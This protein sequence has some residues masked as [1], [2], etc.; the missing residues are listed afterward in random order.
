MLKTL[1]TDA[2]TGLQA[3]VVDREEENALVVATR[4]LKTFTNKVIFFSND[5]YGIDMNVKPIS[6]GVPEKVHNG[7]DNVL[8][9]ASDIVGG[10]KTAFD[11]ADQNH[12]GGG[13]KSV[14]IDNSP[15]ND[16]F[17][18]D[19]GSDLDCSGYA[20]LTMWIYVDKDW[21]AGD[22]IK[23]YG[24][25]TGTGL[26]VGTAV[27]L[28]NYFFWS[29]F[30][31]WRKLTIPLTDMGALASYT[32]LDALR[33][34]ITAAE[35]KSPKFYIDDIQFEESGLPI[36]YTIEPTIGTW[37]HVDQINT[38]MADALNTVLENASMYN[39]SYDKFLGVSEL[40]AGL[41]YQEYHNNKVTLSVEFH[42]LLHFLQM[43]SS[44]TLNV[45]CDVT[46]TWLNLSQTFGSPILLKAED[47]D[48]LVISVRDDMEGLL[49]FRMSMSCR[50]EQR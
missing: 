11:S 34:V 36:E 40:D 38:V 42:N 10:V 5:T 43:P 16:V 32:T 1:I 33:V 23:L 4:P 22:I 37:L 39:L 21:K 30:K 9:T 20:V 44:N 48:K 2:A 25:D 31:V 29:G 46:N 26:Q 41:L 17:Q 8:W 18:F 47:E 13:A 19:K 49:A 28:S 7:I 50:E 3:K 15:I 45:G 6:G 12:T 14:K 24:W 27:D 35:G